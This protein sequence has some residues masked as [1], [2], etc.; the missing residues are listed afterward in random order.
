MARFSNCLAVGLTLTLLTI[1]AATGATRNRVN[2]ASGVLVEKGERNPWTNLDLN[3]RPDTFRFAVISDR[4]GGHRPGVFTRAVRMI[5]MLQ[6]EFVMSVGDLIEGHS[7]DPGQWAL[8]WSEFEG[9]LD[10]LQMPF[11]F[12]PG[13]HDITNLPMSDNWRRKFGRSYYSF[14]YRDV[15]FLVLNSEEPRPKSERYKF[16]LEQQQWVRET[17]RQNTGVRW[18]FI[19]F[20]K[21]VWLM[22]ETDPVAEGW[23]PIEEALQAN[24]RHYTVFVGHIHN[25]AKFVRNGH[26]YFMLA[27]TGGSSKMRGVEFGEFDHVA[28]VT[29]KSD[30]PI[31]A[32][33]LLD[34]VQPNDVRTADEFQEAQSQNSRR[35][36]AP[37]SVGPFR[38]RDGSAPGP[39]PSAPVPVTK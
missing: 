2:D 24:S 25:Y 15:L 18:T 33:V 6:P 19:F 7:Q 3:N 4:T 32:N 28:W 17:L 5:N 21:P 16:G 34:G 12:C 10:A 20:H 26:E 38:R 14:R 35:T 23:T 1:F 31:V 9:K 37:R 8:E 27:T 29:M 11:F 30:G 13:N 22:T 39:T 36:R